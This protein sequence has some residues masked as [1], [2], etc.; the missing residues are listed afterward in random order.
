MDKTQLRQ[1]LAQNIQFFSKRRHD[2][3][4]LLLVIG[5]FDISSSLDQAQE[6]IDK[7]DALIEKLSTT[8]TYIT[9]NGVI[10]QYEKEQF[11]VYREKYNVAN[12]LSKYLVQSAFDL[13][14]EYKITFFPDENTLFKS[15]KSFIEF[16]AN[17]ILIN[18][19]NATKEQKEKML[20][21]KKDWEQILRW[22]RLAI[23]KNDLPHSLDKKESDISIKAWETSKNEFNITFTI[24]VYAISL[25]KNNAEDKGL[26]EATIKATGYYNL[27]EK[28]AVNPYGMKF[29]GFNLTHPTIDHTKR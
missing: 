1:K 24:P 27:T 29:S 9:D 6:N 10:K 20:A 12:V 11:D 19:E 7:K 3:V 13:T 4:I 2:L 21:A 15:S 14:N 16:F 23:N 17:F 25:N 8:T 28:S 18:E 5:F 22:F 26:A